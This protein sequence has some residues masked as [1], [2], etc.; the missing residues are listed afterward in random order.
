[1]PENKEIELRSEEVQDILTRMPHWMI[2]WG[3]VVILI[4]I[5]FVF[6]FSWLI[7]YPDIVTTEIVIT[8][9]NPPERLVAKSTGRITHL[10]IQ[11]GS[12]VTGKNPLAIIENP[13]DYQDVYFLKEII[14]KTDIQQ[15]VIS[16]PVEQTSSLQLGAV[17]SSYAVFEKDYI[18][19]QLNS[20]LQPYNIDK[21]AQQLENIEQ[22][23]R[24]KLL[25]QQKELAEKEMQYKKM[26]LERH[27]RLL[28]KG[29]IPAQEYETKNIEFLQQEKNINNLVSQISSIRSSLNTLGKEK[30]TTVLS[31]TKD[32][33]TLKRNLILS[34][35]QLKK[36]IADWELSYVLQSSIDGKITFLQVWS[37][38]QSIVSGDHVFV[39]VPDEAKDFIGK[40]KAPALNSGKIRSGQE[41]NIRLTNYPDREFGML[42]G[43]VKSLSMVPDKENNLLID[44]ELPDGLETSYHK[45]IV[46]RQEMSGTADIIT[47]NLRL[48]ERL[49]YQFRDF[50]N[51][52][53]A[54]TA[55]KKAN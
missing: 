24:L 54:N 19:Y 44:I 27:Q 39:V 49:L 17:E 2:R 46:F 14:D 3:S 33:L 20:D 34:F 31:E 40:V 42:K 22:R 18:A 50:F 23:E 8:T 21:N 10:L 26:E 30:Q 25:M 13:A 6:I 48:I 29:V 41:V 32:R 4:I 36:A 12:K 11:D 16:F 15:N 53:S 45:E 43:K 7:K 9:Q 28:D 37:A 55:T 1:M 35:N 38:H 52:S 47:E 5:L 51:R